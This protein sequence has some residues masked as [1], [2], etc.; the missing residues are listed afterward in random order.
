MHKRHFALG[1]G[2]A[3]DGRGEVAWL[4][5]C[6]RV[7]IQRGMVTI[8]ERLSVMRAAGALTTA[9]P[10]RRRTRRRPPRQR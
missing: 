3:G 2:E 5:R 7:G 1:R 8:A 6:E 4:G 10:T 9:A